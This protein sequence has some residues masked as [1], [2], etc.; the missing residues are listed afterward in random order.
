MRE[1]TYDE[2]VSLLES[3]VSD[4]AEF[5][6]AVDQVVFSSPPREP[7]HIYLGVS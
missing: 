5:L 3:N 7:S 4:L 1:L 2:G 6:E